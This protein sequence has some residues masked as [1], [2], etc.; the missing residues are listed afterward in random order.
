MLN[1]LISKS[2]SFRIQNPDTE[3]K[4]KTDSSRD[5]KPKLTSAKEKPTKNENFYQCWAVGG[6]FGFLG[7]AYTPY[8]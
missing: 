3:I 4:L 7:S 5:L 2:I 6:Q 8:S 1:I